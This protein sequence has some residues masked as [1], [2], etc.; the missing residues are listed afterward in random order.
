MTRV[1][2]GIQPSGVPT[3]GNYLGAIRNWVPMQDTHESIFCVVDL[4]AITQWQDPKELARQTRE[5]AAALIACGLDPRRC[6]LFIQSHVHAHAR[7]AWIFNCVARIGWLNRMTQFK[8]KAGKDREAASS[9]LYVYPNLMAADILTYHASKVPVGD[10]QKQHL[11][12]ANDIAQKFNHDYGVDFFPTI[13]PLIQGVAA[14]VMSLR[15]GTRKMSKSDPSDQSRINLTDDHDTIALKIR[16]ARTDSEPLPDHAAGLEGRAE[17]RNLVGILAG[18][19][20]TLPENVL[21]E[22]G[23]KGFSEFKE[24]LV[25]ALVAHLD[26]IRTEMARLLDDPA[27]LD[28]EL[29]LG[30]DRAE[31]IAAPICARAEEIV[32]FLPRR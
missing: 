20:N 4:H 22:H 21:R 14:R 17:A 23:G 9:G 7:L 32:G 12:L 2:S 13:E 10:D 1:F 24:V 5:M 26:P 8:D 16:R 6:I 30:A 27:A 29:R 28:A 19:T 15:D 3:L 31:A 11:E 25:A 18:I